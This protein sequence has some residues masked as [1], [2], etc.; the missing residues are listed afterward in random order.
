MLQL[1]EQQRRERLASSGAKGAENSFLSTTR[2]LT[3]QCS[4]G[5][6]VRVGN[7]GL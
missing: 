6:I 5:S 3:N 2:T 7:R 1:T 4:K